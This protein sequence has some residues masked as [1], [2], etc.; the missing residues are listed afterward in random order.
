M[1]EHDR[2]QQLCAK[3]AEV[4][5]V[6][7]ALSISPMDEGDAGG[8]H[9]PERFQPKS[10]SR[11]VERFAPDNGPERFGRRLSCSPMQLKIWGNCP[12]VR[13]RFG[14]N[15]RTNLVD[16]GLRRSLAERADAQARHAL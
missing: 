5:S 16:I 7:M 9:S 3:P 12:V 13:A 11:S 8:E 2:Q 6:V 14:K 4:P 10:R 15:T 1:R